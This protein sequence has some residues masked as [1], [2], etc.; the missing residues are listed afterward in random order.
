MHS[1]LRTPGQALKLDG[2]V[3]LNYVR[4]LRASRTAS[5]PGR[6]QAHFKLTLARQLR[7]NGIPRAPSDCPLSYT[8]YQGESIHVEGGITF[9]LSGFDPN[10]IRLGVLVP[11]W[12]IRI[13][14]SEN[15]S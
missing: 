13:L 11:P 3:E 6:D 7:V 12:I 10:G 9:N 5:A 2:I 1:F 15:L 14:R 4:T 8:L